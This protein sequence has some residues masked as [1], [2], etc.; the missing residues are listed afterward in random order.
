MDK[1]DQAIFEIETGK[2]ISPLQIKLFDKLQKYD[3]ICFL[4]SRQM[5]FSFFF[6]FYSL[7]YAEKNPKTRILY[8]CLNAYHQK[9]FFEKIQKTTFVFSKPSFKP[10]LNFKNGS[11]I[12]INS[13]SNLKFSYEVEK[14][15][16][17]DEY[18]LVLLDEIGWFQKPNFI[19]KILSVAKKAYFFSSYTPSFIDYWNFF[20]ANDYETCTY[21][22]HSNENFSIEDYDTHTTYMSE[23]DIKTQLFCEFR[24]M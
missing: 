23:E 24:G 21:P 8:I 12:E 18:D 13:F 3:M 2:R 1:E 16:E 10:I 14:S 5:G 9:A 11:T 17:I 4:K 7:Y 20:K 19:N 15:R 6:S 22:W